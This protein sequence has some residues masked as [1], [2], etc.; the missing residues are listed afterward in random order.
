M[1]AS[2]R[3]Y[4]REPRVL[5]RQLAALLVVGVA[6]SVL[7]SY[8]SSRWL[9]LAGV[10]LLMLCGAGVF[11]V[12][13]RLFTRHHPTISLFADR[14]WFRGLREEVVMLR[15]VRDARLVESRVAGWTRRAIQLRLNGDGD[16]QRVTV[17]L[18]A[19]DADPAEVVSLISERAAQQRQQL[20][21]R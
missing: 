7:M 21:V 10:A 18:D 17:P 8:A 20:A 9:E 19:L 6:I 11:I 2:R 15:N 12:S 1:D 14:L 13:A 16:A 3:D 5:Q 4:F